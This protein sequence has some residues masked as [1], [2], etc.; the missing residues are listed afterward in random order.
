MCVCSITTLQILSRHNTI[1]AISIE[2]IR[3]LRKYKSGV[4]F[5]YCPNKCVFYD[6]DIP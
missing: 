1:R 5:P 4:R 2:V 3:V 6:I